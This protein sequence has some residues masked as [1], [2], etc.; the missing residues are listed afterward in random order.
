MDIIQNYTIRLINSNIHN[1][2]NLKK[3]K[4]KRNF[5]LTAFI[6]ILINSISFSQDLAKWN[7]QLKECNHIETTSDSDNV[8]KSKDYAN[9]PQPHERI[10]GE[11]KTRDYIGLRAYYSGSQCNCKDNLSGHINYKTNEEIY[12]SIK[13]YANAEYGESYPYFTIR[14]AKYSIRYKVETNYGLPFTCGTCDEKYE[15]YYIFMTATIVVS[16]QVFNTVTKPTDPLNRALIKALQD[17]REGS[18]LALDQIKT[19]NGNKEDFKDQIVEIL[20]DEGYKVVAKDYLEKLY[21]EQQ[22]QQS[23]IFNDRTTVKENNFSAIG[24]FINVKQTETAIKVQVINVSTGE[25]DANV[26]VKLE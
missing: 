5:I 18:R 11:I 8:W 10:I 26:T 4:T 14:D 6:S 25:Y 20:L 15:H 1:S 16:N 13:E 12:E 19:T 21:E 24:Y 22:A 23:G 9:S 17:I 2:L 3:M 7:A